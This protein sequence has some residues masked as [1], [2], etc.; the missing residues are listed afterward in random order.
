VELRSLVAVEHLPGGDE[1][2]SSVQLVFDSTLL[3]RAPDL[4]LQPDEVEEVHWLAPDLAMERHGKGGQAG[5]AAALDARL[6]GATAYLDR[7]RR[8]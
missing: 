6:R 8:L 3:G 4:V 2:P 5:L 1:R 7:D